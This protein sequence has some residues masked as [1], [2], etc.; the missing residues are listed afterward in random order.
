[1]VFSF[2]SLTGSTRTVIAILVFGVL[3]VGLIPGAKAAPNI[4]LSPT[5]GPTGTTVYIYGSGFTPNGQIHSALWNGTNAY[6]F[7]ADANGNL[8]T[9]VTV[10]D[11]TAGNY[12]FTVTDVAT[13]SATQTQFTVT[14]SS[15]SSTPTTTS[16]ATASPVPTSSIPEFQSTFIVLT[17]FAAVSI[18]AILIARKRK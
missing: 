1:M 17:L 11:V 10:P 2:K 12:G 4:T 15:T 9:T 6:D 14:Q 18:G 3:I 5:S 7:N 8:N 16:T 13:G